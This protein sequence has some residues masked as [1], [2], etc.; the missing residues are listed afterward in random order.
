VIANQHRGRPNA[1]L[2]ASGCNH[3]LSWGTLCALHLDVFKSLIGH[4][5]FT[6]P[7]ITTIPINMELCRYLIQLGLA[8][9]AS[10]ARPHD[11]CSCYLGTSRTR[12][13]LTF[14]GAASTSE[15]DV[16]CPH[17]TNNSRSRELVLVKWLKRRYRTIK[18]PCTRYRRAR[19]CRS[20][21]T[22]EHAAITYRR[23]LAASDRHAASS[24]ISLAKGRSLHHVAEM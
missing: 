14:C 8:K 6:P 3:T 7:N 20:L 4:C 12:L 11:P 10:I 23:P 19:R 2:H 18:R 13:G 1:L 16:C 21:I 5:A 22:Q 24:M 15:Y 17:L 9:Y